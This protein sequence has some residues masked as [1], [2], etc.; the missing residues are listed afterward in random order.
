[1]TAA[2]PPAFSIAADTRSG[3]GLVS[4]TSEELVQPSASSPASSSSITNRPRARAPPRDDESRSR[5]GALALALVPAL[6]ELLDE[7]RAERGQVVGLARG[8]EAVVD[9]HLLV[10]PVRA[11]VA[12]VGPQ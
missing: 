3:A 10:D 8:D 7:L 5:A 9:V 1:M 12:Q 6:G 4:C 11:R 2:P